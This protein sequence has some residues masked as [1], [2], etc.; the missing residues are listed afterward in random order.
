MA[1]RVA[2]Y[3]RVST[4]GKGQD[5]ENQ[6]RQLREWCRHM[7]HPV[8]HEYV[9]H[10]NGGK[11]V[12]YRKQLGAMFA[13][14]ARREFDLLLVWSLDRFSREGMAATIGHLQRL[15]SHGVGFRSFTEEHLSTENELVRNILLATLASL[16]KLEREK[17][18]QRTKA[19][20]ERARAMGKRLGR[21]QF[22]DGDRHK[23]RAALDMGTS[24]HAVSQATKIPYST[25]K[26]H[27]RLLGYE[28]QRADVKIA[29]VEG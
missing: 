20:L 26:K 19:G 22:S 4:D 16:A 3:A 18:S 24:W 8:V 2:I 25:V 17:I 9:E 23:L 1:K 27:A 11:G 15:S 28:P 5:P 13:G 12:E 29:M 10:E 7:G 14:A 6:L 21:A